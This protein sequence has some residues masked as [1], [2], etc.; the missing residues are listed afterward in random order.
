MQQQ[1]S[2]G[3]RQTWA[4]WAWRRMVSSMCARPTSPLAVVLCPLLMARPPL[5][6]PL[7]GQQ[8]HFRSGFKTGACSGCPRLPRKLPLQTLAPSQV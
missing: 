2:Q 8:T 1:S 3:L 7:P 6:Q 4:W 5:Q